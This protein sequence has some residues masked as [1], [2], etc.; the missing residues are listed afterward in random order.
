MTTKCFVSW[1]IALTASE[2]CAAQI[3]IKPKV[4]HLKKFKPSEWWKEV[5]KLSGRSLASTEAR[6]SCKIPVRC[7]DRKKKA[8]SCSRTCDESNCIKFHSTRSNSSSLSLS[9]SLDFCL[10]N[11]LSVKNKALSL[12][13]SMILTSLPWQKL[14]FTKGRVTTFLLAS[15]AW[16]DIFSII[17][18]EWTQEAVEL[19]F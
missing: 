17:L 10:W 18:L 4:E 1:Q 13:L 16:K 15:Y 9:Q 7:P 6:S 8:T 3:I 5:K 19:V 12:R 14:G 11:V 2:R